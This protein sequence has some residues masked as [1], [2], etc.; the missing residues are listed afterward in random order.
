MCNVSENQ[1]AAVLGIPFGAWSVSADANFI[2]EKLM[3]EDVY[4][5]QTG[6]SAASAGGI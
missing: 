4:K 1:S 6:A 3:R 2:R 5:R